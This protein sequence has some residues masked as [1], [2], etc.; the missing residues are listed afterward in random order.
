MIKPLKMIFFT[1]SLREK[2]LL[3]FVHKF[4]CYETLIGDERERESVKDGTN[5]MEKYS[6]SDFA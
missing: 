4:M 1:L 6:L 3:R 5:G 2:K